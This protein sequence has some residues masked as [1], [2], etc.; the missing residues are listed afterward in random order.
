VASPQLIRAD[1]DDDV[2][3][4]VRSQRRIFYEFR[5]SLSVS[6]FLRSL[7]NF[8][9]VGCAT[10]IAVAIANQLFIPKAV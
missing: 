8:P 9:A 4:V 6:K 10:K 7:K 1:D 5:K 3:V 2:V